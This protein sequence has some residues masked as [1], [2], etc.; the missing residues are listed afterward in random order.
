MAIHA[1]IFADPFSEEAAYKPIPLAYGDENST[2]LNLPFTKTELTETICHTK[3]TTVGVDKISAALFK[4]FNEY[5][6][7]CL[8]QVHYTIWISGDIPSA[9]TSAAFLSILKLWKPKTDIES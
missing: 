6:L 5:S 1:E 3:T 7:E 8:L 2:K 9:W 4:G